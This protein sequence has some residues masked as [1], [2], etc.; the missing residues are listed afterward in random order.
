[1]SRFRQSNWLAA[2]CHTHMADAQNKQ[3]QTSLSTCIFKVYVREMPDI[4]LLI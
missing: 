3:Q 1:M 2:K 4:L